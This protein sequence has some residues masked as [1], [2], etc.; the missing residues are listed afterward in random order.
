MKEA[1]TVLLFSLMAVALLTA[2]SCVD[3]AT[4]VQPK[5][6]AAG[7][8][9]KDAAGNIVYERTPDGGP[10]GWV[11]GLLGIGG[12]A[13][14]VGNVWLGIRNRSWS[15]V[16]TGVIQSYN[17]AK[18]AMTPEERAKVGALLGKAQEKLGIRDRV[19]LLAKADE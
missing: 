14:A 3:A 13:S 6:D 12:I 18:S 1:C 11:G 16:A 2:A 8:V 15:G 19:R 4:G 10:I 7:N 17:E 5:K 9:V